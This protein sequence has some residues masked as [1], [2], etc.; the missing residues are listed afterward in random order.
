MTR[1]FPAIKRIEVANAA[2][3]NKEKVSVVLIL[4]KIR[5]LSENVSSASKIPNVK[6]RLWPVKARVSS[7]IL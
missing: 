5:I 2:Y 1:F 7:V 3:P 4:H 6:E